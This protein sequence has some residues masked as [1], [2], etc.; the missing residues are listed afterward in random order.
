[1]NITNF[2]KSNNDLDR[3]PFLT[4]YQTILVLLKYG[5]LDETRA[6]NGK[7]DKV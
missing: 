5:F 4:V 7:L 6:V 2:I 3:L 1:M